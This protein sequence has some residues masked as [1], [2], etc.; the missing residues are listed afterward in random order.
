MLQLSRP[1]LQDTEK[2]GAPRLCTHPCS[3]SCPTAKALCLF[4]PPYAE[5]KVIMSNRASLTPP[6]QLQLHPVFQAFLWADLF[7]HFP[8]IVSGCSRSLWLLCEHEDPAVA[9]SLTDSPFA[10]WLCSRG[11]CGLRSGCPPLGAL[12]E[13]FD[14]ARLLRTKVRQNHPYAAAA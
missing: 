7:F 6:K 5:T 9:F 8:S 14:A 3:P 11:R 2:F 4:Q 12:P 1:E 13:P 10:G